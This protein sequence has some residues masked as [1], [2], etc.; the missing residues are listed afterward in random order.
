MKNLIKIKTLLVVASLIVFTN[1]QAEKEKDF[2][3]FGEEDL[4][5]LLT[6]L[7]TNR[8]FVDTADGEILDSQN[9][10]IYKKCSVGQVHRSEG[11]DCRGAQSGSLFTPNDNI[12][13]GATQLAYCNSNTWACNSRDFPFPA[14]ANAPIDLGSNSIQGVSQAFNACN[15]LNDSNG[16]PGWRLP[17]PVELTRLTLG[18]RNAMLTIFPDTQEEWYWTAWG[19]ADDLDGVTALAISFERSN[20]GEEKAF[21]KTGRKYV[22]CVRSRTPTSN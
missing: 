18:G 3:G 16:F 22:R 7:V 19:R 10:I 13:W 20:F 4:G 12:R 2:F 14:V 1:C 17:T 9:G 21:Q 15:S 11:N 8:N 6:G 5:L